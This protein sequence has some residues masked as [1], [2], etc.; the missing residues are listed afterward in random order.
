MEQRHIPKLLVDM[1]LNLFDTAEVDQFISVLHILTKF[2]LVLQQ[3]VLFLFHQRHKCL[4]CILVHLPLDFR[5]VL[6]CIVCNKM[7]LKFKGRFCYAM[8]EILETMPQFSD[9][10]D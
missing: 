5:K 3:K 8:I 7:K 2:G 1:K 9:Q 4:L 6:L 10:N